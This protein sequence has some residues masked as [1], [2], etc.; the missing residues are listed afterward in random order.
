MDE[1]KGAPPSGEGRGPARRSQPPPDPSGRRG[2]TRPSVT[3]RAFTYAVLAAVLMSGGLALAFGLGRGPAAPV[4]GR[5]PAARAKAHAAHGSGA[6]AASSD[7]G[8]TASGTRQA[9]YPPLGEATAPVPGP[10]IAGFGWVYSSA[11]GAYAYHPGWAFK[12]SLGEPVKAVLGGRVEANWVDPTEGREAVVDSSNGDSLVYGDLAG[13]GPKVGTRLTAGQVFARVG[14]VGRLSKGEAVHLF[15]GLTVDGHPVS[16][17][18][19]LKDKVAI[20]PAT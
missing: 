12:A 18:V 9:Y 16:P 19:L 3:T 7:T 2:G 13:D 1:H 15:L 6:K 10:V 20:R 5:P 11:L 17:A 14:P 4:S 8:R